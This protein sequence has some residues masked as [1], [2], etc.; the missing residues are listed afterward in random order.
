MLPDCFLAVLLQFHPFLALEI[1]LYNPPSVITIHKCIYL[2][3]VGSSGDLA[4]LYIPFTLLL[5][6]GSLL[7]HKVSECGVLPPDA[8]L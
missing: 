5:L 3:L 7:G 4:H 8:S 1:C 6:L 2:R